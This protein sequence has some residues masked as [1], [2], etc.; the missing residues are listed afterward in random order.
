MFAKK[1]RYL[2]LPDTVATDAQG[3]SFSCKTLRPLPDVIGTFSHTVEEGDR[4]DHLAYKYYKQS[5]RWWRICDANPGY[6]APQ[7]LLG[8]GPFVT[9][10]FPLTYHGDGQPPWCDLLRNLSGR[11]GIENIEIVD[12]I[13]LVEREIELEGPDTTYIGEHPQRG[14]KIVFNRF[15]LSRKAIIH[16]IRSVGFNAGDPYDIGRVGKKITIP[17]DVAG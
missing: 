12:D 4:F 5:A 8:K 17:P 7:A 10:Y 14:V 3:R 11:A 16:E 6:M 15:N 1:S 2:K 13:R 9:T